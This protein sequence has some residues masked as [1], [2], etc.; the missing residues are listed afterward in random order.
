MPT[1]FSKTRIDQMAALPLGQ[2]RRVQRIVRDELRHGDVPMERLHYLFEPCS[3][4]VIT[5]ELWRVTE[6]QVRVRRKT[7]IVRMK[8][9]LQ[10][11]ETMRRTLYMRRHRA[12]K[13]AEAAN[14]RTPNT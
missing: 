7:R 5:A 11:F 13:K 12:K 8:A 3:V 6:V 1:S 9:E 10:D 2:W 14:E 4:K